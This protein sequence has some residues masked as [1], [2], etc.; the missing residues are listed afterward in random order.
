MFR[1]ASRH[2]V[3]RLALLSAPV[4]S[5]AYCF[6]DYLDEEKTSVLV[7]GGGTAGI[8]IAA[9]LRRK[10]ES[11]TIVEPSDVHY[12]QPMWTLVGGGIKQNTQVCWLC[13]ASAAN[14]G[15][16]MILTNT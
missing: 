8:G 15:T 2:V 11:V 4:A 5:I 14:N 13:A 1:Q 9:Q 10:G 16:T 12:Y 7:I 6:A 3:S